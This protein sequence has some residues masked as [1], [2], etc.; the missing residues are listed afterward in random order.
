MID[1]VFIVL[2]R[3]FLATTTRVILSEWWLLL[4]NDCLSYGSGSFSISEVA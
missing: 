3:C 2:P 4:Y 1:S